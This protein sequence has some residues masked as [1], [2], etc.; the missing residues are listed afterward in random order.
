MSWTFLSNHG[1]VMV[2][3]AQNPDSRVADLAEA[4]GITERRVAAILA[5]LQDAGY[6]SVAKKGRQNVYSVK[7]S[8]KLRH[9][10]ESSKSVGDLLGIFE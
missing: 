2:Q 5:D 6:I 10:A 7:R 8:K 9:A 3:L 4:V 1:H